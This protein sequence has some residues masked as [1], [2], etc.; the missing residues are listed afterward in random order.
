MTD[1]VTRLNA[2]LSGRYRIERQ[3]GEG[4]MAV[5]ERDP[6]DLTESSDPV[7]RLKVT[8]PHRLLA[9]GTLL[10]S[11]ACGG[12]KEPAGPSGPTQPVVATIE[13]SPSE[14]TLASVGVDQQFSAV[15]KDASRTPISG[16]S[17]AWSS[18]NV[19]VASVDASSGLA[20]TIGNGTT[21]ITATPPMA[22]G[23]T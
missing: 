13:V 14:Q 20:T 11:V 18:S 1:P 16:Q 7:V 4:G 21:T 15:A 9:F 19:S 12:D 6:G 3:L 22:L 10:L 5:G 23:L 2:A 17:F 8:G